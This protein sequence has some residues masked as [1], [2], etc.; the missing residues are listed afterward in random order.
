M[1]KLNLETCGPIWKA[2]KW[3]YK[4]HLWNTKPRSFL[5]RF[6]HISLLLADLIGSGPFKI[7]RQ[8]G[9]GDVKGFGSPIV[10]LSLKYLGD[11]FFIIVWRLK[12]D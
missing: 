6:G 5:L 12:I 2:W 9:L 10:L 3:P 7:T 11:W 4:C 1:F 8:D